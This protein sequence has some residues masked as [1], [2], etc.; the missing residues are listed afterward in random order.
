MFLVSKAVMFPTLLF[1]EKAGLICGCSLFGLGLGFFFF[2]LEGFFSFSLGRLF[3][4]TLMFFLVFW[5][6]CWFILKCPT[7]CYCLDFIAHLIDI[8]VS[9]ICTLNRS[10]WVFFL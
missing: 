7:L 3:F 8:F 9:L 5:F 1:A 4:A 10:A 6:V 2:L